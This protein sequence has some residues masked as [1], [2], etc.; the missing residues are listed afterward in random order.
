MNASYKRQ[1][2]PVDQAG[3]DTERG[4]L[5]SKKGKKTAQSVLNIL[6]FSYNKPLE[7]FDSNANTPNFPAE[8][9]LPCAY[10][11]ATIIAPEYK[12]DPNLQML[13]EQK[14]SMLMQ[15]VLGFDNESRHLFHA[16]LSFAMWTRLQG[17]KLNNGQ[18]NKAMFRQ[19]ILITKDNK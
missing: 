17:Q 14:A 1:P 16:S 18:I 7:I 11:L 13:L 4:S 5:K 8:W 19:C 12:S 10:S 3:E 15:D 2:Q 9:Y 6:R